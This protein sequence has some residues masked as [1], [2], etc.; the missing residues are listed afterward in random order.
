MNMKNF[1]SLAAVA[2]LSLSGCAPTGPSAED[3]VRNTIEYKTLSRFF[4]SAGGLQLTICNSSDMFEATIKA[5]LV[6]DLNHSSND[7]DTPEV[8]NAISQLYKDACGR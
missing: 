2:L 3:Q 6:I 7:A 8:A 1:L 4:D 5:D